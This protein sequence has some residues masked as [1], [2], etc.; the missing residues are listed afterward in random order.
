MNTQ[1]LKEFIGSPYNKIADVKMLLFFLDISNFALGVMIL[2]AVGSLFISNFWCRYLCP[3]GALLGLLGFF[4]PIKI[5]RNRSSCT[6]CL[7]CTRVCPAMINVHKAGIVRSDE[8]MSCLECVKVCPVQDTLYPAIYGKKRLSPRALAVGVLAIFVAFWITARITGLWKNNISD[9]EY[10][11][12]VQHIDGL[13][14][15]HIR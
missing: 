13:E 11:Y 4:S 2:L 8:C 9:Q 5:K 15:N 6:D 7:A 1:A 3:Y 10:I 14:Y 12:H